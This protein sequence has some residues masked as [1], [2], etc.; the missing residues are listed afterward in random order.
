MYR[1]LLLFLF[2]PHFVFAQL[3]A[4]RPVHLKEV[5]AVEKLSDSYPVFFNYAE[6]LEEDQPLQFYEYDS[7]IERFATYFFSKRDSVLTK[8]VIQHAK[9][10]E[11]FSTDITWSDEEYEDLK[12]KY[13]GLQ[14]LFKN[15]YNIKFQHYNEVLPNQIKKQTFL[16]P[17]PILYNPRLTFTQLDLGE[18]KLGVLTEIYENQ[19]YLSQVHKELEFLS[20]Y[21][22]ENIKYGN[23]DIVNQLVNAQMKVDLEQHPEVL[24]ELGNILKNRTYKWVDY[25]SGYSDIHQEY[26]LIY[27]IFDEAGEHD[28]NM[29]I[30]Y[31]NQQDI[32]YIQYSEVQ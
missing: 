1:I 7:K 3:P 14:E 5:L 9:F 10:A 25:N 17:N 8:A 16:S 4:H 24:V 27:H 26:I 2:L 20:Y 12:N 13:F 6:G 23:N 31:N 22:L 28:H 21:F 30:A 29:I 32:I 11:D 15:T 19:A 18:R